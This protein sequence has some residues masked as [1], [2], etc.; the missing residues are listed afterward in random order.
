MKKISGKLIGGLD[1]GSVSANF[2][3]IDEE[4]K[5]VYEQ[6]YIRHN[7]KPIGTAQKIVK[8]IHSRLSFDVL[9][10]TGYNGELLS[11]GW[12]VPYVEEVIA[13]AKGAHHINPSVRTIMDI[14]GLDATF[15]ALDQKGKVTDFGMSSGCASG[16]GSFLDQQ[17]K[18]LELNIEGEFA[19][20][21]LK[22]TNPARLAGRCA[23][24]A[25]SDMIHHQQKG[26][27]LPDI[28]MGL[29][30]A[31]VRNYCSSV[32]RG[33]EFKGPVS[34]QGGVA[35]NEAMFVAFKKVLGRDDIVVLPH[36]FSLGALGAAL[37]LKEK[38][39]T[40]NFNPSFLQS[41]IAVEKERAA[42]PKLSLDFEHEKPP[43]PH[44]E[45]VFPQNGE[46][47]SA[48]LGIDIGSVSTNVAVIDEKGH[49][50][51][52]SYLPTAG[53]PLKAVQDGLR[54]VKGKVEGKAVIRG[55][56]TTGSGRYMTGA[57]IGA[58]VIRNEITAQAKGEEG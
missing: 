12:N 32:A 25:K 21:A 29:C 36:F 18:R 11:K 56:G 54:Q 15:I 27:P 31:L 10:V 16:T 53:K 5:V 45:Y 20:E 42:L 24:F 55:A 1:V 44:K 35:A 13:Q 8:Q 34:F 28:T 33:K 37:L 14:G 22:S 26:T 7:G 17:A 39:D 38:N 49:L 58:D 9:G 3:V 43:F 52:K 40:Q 50:I 51:A 48:W 41:E 4:S 47:V 23:V 19:G 2:V 6:G 30:E 57:F 46:K